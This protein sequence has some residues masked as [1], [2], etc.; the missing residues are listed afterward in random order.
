MKIIFRRFCEKQ[1]RW[2][3]KTE[4][5]ATGKSAI[6]AQ[7]AIFPDPISCKVSPGPEFYW[8]VHW[9]HLMWKMF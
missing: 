9:E 3:G 6:P 7:L 8:T 4:I 2:F 5:M 1:F